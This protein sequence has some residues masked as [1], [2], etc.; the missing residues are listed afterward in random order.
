MRFYYFINKKRAQKAADADAEKK[1]QLCKGTKIITVGGIIGVVVSVD[2]EEKTFVLETEGSV[3]KFD[4]RA[5]YQMEL[6]KG[7]EKA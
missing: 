3:M 4:M 7:K 1:S 6:P 5:I 2:Q